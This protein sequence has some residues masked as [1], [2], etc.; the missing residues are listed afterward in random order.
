MLFRT[1]LGSRPSGPEKR[2]PA[3]TAGSAVR[4]T[5]FPAALSFAAFAALLI[6]CSTT[7]RDEGAPRAD[8]V[9]TAMNDDPSHASARDEAPPP[10]SSEGSEPGDVRN[11]PEQTPPIPTAS[12]EVDAD[13]VRIEK[14]CCP[15]GHY[16]AVHKDKAAA[17]QASLGCD[18]PHA[19][20]L[21]LA[22]DDHSM[23]QCN[24][25][26]R[27]CELV[28]PQDI[29]CNGFTPNP[30]ACPDGFRCRLPEHVTDLPGKCLQQCGGFAGI[31]CEDANAL[32]VDDP[33]DGCD[34]HH[35]GA[36][37]GGLCVGR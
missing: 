32:C 27:A 14:G 12:C 26:T 28:K 6:A 18:E 25:E 2:C 34:P 4:A 35:G 3:R 7:A 17:Y 37:C 8:G 11:V 5:V 13:C 24:W 21:I 36:D 30:H 33:T 16:I 31:V 9:R 15:L 1:S 19:C 10:S 20:P 29:A 23:A 22:V